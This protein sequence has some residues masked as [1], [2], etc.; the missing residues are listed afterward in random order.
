MQQA[1]IA[2]AAPCKLARTRHMQHTSIAHVYERYTAICSTWI[3][4]GFHAACWLGLCMVAPAGLHH[5]ASVTATEP[6]PRSSAAAQTASFH[7]IVQPCHLISAC[8]STCS[9]VPVCYL[10]AHQ[11]FWTPGSRS[12]AAHCVQTDTVFR[13]SNVANSCQ[14]QSRRASVGPA[15]SLQARRVPVVQ[16][17]LRH[18]AQLAS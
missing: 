6:P 18:R 16:T 7:Q 5:D 10:V 15:A 3:A 2:C 17:T 11:E 13:S 9:F 8:I 1:G 12:P 4:H 14:Q